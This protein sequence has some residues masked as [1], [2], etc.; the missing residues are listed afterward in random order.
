ME[1]RPRERFPQSVRLRKRAE[2][3]RVQERGIKVQTKGFIGLVLP[4]PGNVTRIG[5]TTSRRLGKAVVRNHAR[6]LIREAFRT[7]KLN[8]PSGLEL[9]V[10]PR[11]ASTRMSSEQVFAELEQLGKR[12]RRLKEVLGL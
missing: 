7:G 1:S 10:I 6:R 4:R 9:V 5:I 2:Y 3:L 11:A 8:L 12:V